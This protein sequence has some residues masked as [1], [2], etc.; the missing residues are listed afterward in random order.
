MR[1]LPMSRPA[2]PARL[3]SSPPSSNPSSFSRSRSS[4]PYPPGRPASPSAVSGGGPARLLHHHGIRL[5]GSGRRH[6]GI[7]R[8]HQGPQII[9]G[10]QFFQRTQVEVIEE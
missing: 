8:L 7:Y 3:S 9:Q 6:G 5:R 4:P 2:P 10:R 1:A